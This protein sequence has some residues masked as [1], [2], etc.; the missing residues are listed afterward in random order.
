MG[1]VAEGLAEVPRRG[2]LKKR[3]LAEAMVL[4]PKSSTLMAMRAFWSYCGRSDE[5]QRLR[6]ARAFS[7]HLPEALAP[8]LQ[9][10]QQLLQLPLGHTVKMLWLREF[11]AL[12]LLTV[13]GECF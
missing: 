13:L 9:G 4:M 11:S 7:R 6:G 1:A 5:H 2:R 10:A 3:A 12:H 8:S